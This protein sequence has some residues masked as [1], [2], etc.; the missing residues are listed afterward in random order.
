MASLNKTIQ[1]VVQGCTI[2][3]KWLPNG[4]HNYAKDAQGCTILYK[5][6]PKWCTKVQNYQMSHWILNSLVT[7]DETRGHN[8]VKVYSNP[9]VIYT[10]QS[11]DCSE[12]I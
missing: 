2:L 10:F 11:I 4:V 1:R 9:I 7:E 5:G 8:S 6:M 3:Y 12:F